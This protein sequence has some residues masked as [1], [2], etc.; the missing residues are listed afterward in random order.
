MLTRVSSHELY[1]TVNHQV[2]LF[3]FLSHNRHNCRRR[4]LLHHQHV[5]HPKR[6]SKPLIHKSTQCN[7]HKSSGQNLASDATHSRGEGGQ[8]SRDIYDVIKFFFPHVQLPGRDCCHDYNV[9]TFIYGAEQSENP[10]HYKRKSWVTASRTRPCNNL[11][12]FRFD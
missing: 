8:H 6:G 12:V 5:H 9:S 1:F 2:F 11:C 3:G 4:H 10:K 7:R